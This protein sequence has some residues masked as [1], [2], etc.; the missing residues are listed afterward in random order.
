MAAS[1]L[2]LEEINQI[3]RDNYYRPFYPNKNKNFEQFLV[4]SK[5]GPCWYRGYFKDN[6]TQKQIDRGLDKFNAKSVIVGHTIQYK[7]NRQYNGKVIGIDVHHPTDHNKYWPKRKS[8]A[9]LI[10]GDNYY[11]VYNNGEKEELLK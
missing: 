1:N 3:I 8:E 6:L 9:L 10:D 5:T 11:R 7:V 4:S 2:S